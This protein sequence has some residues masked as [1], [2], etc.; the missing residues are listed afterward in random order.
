MGAMRGG[1]EKMEMTG[2]K[3]ARPGEKRRG[4]V[5]W[6]SET[7]G[8]ETKKDNIVRGK[9]VSRGDRKKVEDERR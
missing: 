2:K 5:T 7:E 6:A 4:E 9:A 3:V 8:T 1:G